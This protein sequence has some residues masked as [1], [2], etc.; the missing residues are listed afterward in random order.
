ML[1]RENE[2]PMTSHAEKQTT[3]LRKGSIHQHLNIELMQ[4]HQKRMQTNSNVKNVLISP[5]HEL[6]PHVHCT[7]RNVYK[8]ATP[9]AIFDMIF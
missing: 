6:P 1:L 5:V 8:M 3:L 2:V 9:I 7:H 4:T